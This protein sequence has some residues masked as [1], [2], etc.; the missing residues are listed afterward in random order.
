MVTL[1]AT[2]GYKQT[3]WPHEPVVVAAIS[4]SARAEAGSQ[5]NVAGRAEHLDGI[6]VVLEA[7]DDLAHHEGRPFGDAGH[8]DTD[9]AVEPAVRTLELEVPHR[10]LNS[11]EH[12]RGV[13]TALRVLLQDVL[14]DLT[15]ADAG[16]Q[17]ARDQRP[18]AG[19]AEGDVA[20]CAVLR[21]R[22]QLQMLK[23]PR[24]DAKVIDHEPATGVEGEGHAP[25]GRRASTFATRV[26]LATGRLGVEVRVQNQPVR[27]DEEVQR[28]KTA[29][30]V[31]PPGSA[32][33]VHSADHVL[34]DLDP[35]NTTCSC[36]CCAHAAGSPVG[37]REAE[38]AV[39]GVNQGLAAGADKC[40]K[41][42]FATTNKTASDIPAPKIQHSQIDVQE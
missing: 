42:G 33:R 4:Y 28:C 32:C 16:R 12:A 15:R 20:S 7:V 2:P 31:A 18:S 22:L 35:E 34:R 5:R 6:L 10:I 26:T 39:Q 29:G 19:A 8:Q 41:E 3:A 25:L 36:S 40:R 11:R 21:A 30:E 14:E 24:T 1:A 38:A 13:A 27:N 17:H 9:A 37:Q 23:Q